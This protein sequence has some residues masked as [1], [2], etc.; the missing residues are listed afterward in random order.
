MFS[1]FEGSF[2][3]QFFYSVFKDTIAL[4]M[5][6][7]FFRLWF[8]W[9]PI[10][11]GYIF[12]K[13]W[14]A[15]VRNYYI[16][17]DERVLLEIKV[18]REMKKTP[19]AIEAVFAA[20]Y[21]AREAN[22]YERFWEGF[23]PAHYSFEIASIGG[24]I[25]FYVEC[26]KFFQ[27]LIES[28]FYSQFTGLEIREAEDYTSLI[29]KKIPN[30][31]WD[32]RGMEF[33]L[34]KEDAFPI[35]TYVDVYEMK[36]KVV[37]EVKE[38]Y[39]DP[40]SSLFEFF[41]S[42][43]EGEHLWFQILVESAGKEWREEVDKLHKKLTGKK[44]FEFAAEIPRFTSPEESVLKAIAR[45]TTKPGFKTGIR[46]IY[47]ARR[48]VFS[49]L[50]FAAV[51]GIIKQFNSPVL[52]SFRLLRTTRARYFF[53]KWREAD[54]KK[55]MLNAF[56]ERSY[57]HYPYIR[58]YFI[59]NTEELA[60]IYHFPVMFTEVPALERI[61]SRKMKPPPFLPT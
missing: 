27:S 28:H 34:E 36:L 39:V 5:A 30:E 21:E 14:L 46:V 48:E 41:G 10:F 51:Q 31:E 37:E 19:A 54:R 4:E 29:P 47:L 8:V 17:N 6:V 58:P 35:L 3:Y 32:L 9:L 60:T 50:A 33:D 38:H 44:R 15:W 55:R 53:K 11:L 56:R 1:L 25:H 49:P 61:E 12:V 2:A 20:L 13:M 43:K 59:L 24:K 26:P 7:V 52:N 22:F 40:L 18:P 23:V 42:L 57:F 16:W 45:A